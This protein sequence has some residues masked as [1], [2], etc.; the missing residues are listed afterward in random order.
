MYRSTNSPLISPF[1]QAEATHK[2][3]VIASL[4]KELHEL[5]D[6]ETDFV[7]LNDEIAA[8]ESKYALLLDE[9]D[10]NEKE[11]R[12]KMD[13]N[14]KTILDMRAD[15]DSLK[16]QIHKASVEVEDTLRENTT[17]KRMCDNRAT[18][19]SSLMA[20]NREL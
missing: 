16:L 7:R 19:I 10:R 5:R 18:E 20:S 15:I 6:L 11:H 3:V 1:E 8:L 2:D 4:K 14:K 9:K 12:V 17:L 13:I